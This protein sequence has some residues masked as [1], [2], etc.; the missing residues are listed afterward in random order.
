MLAS[1][2]RIIIWSGLN[3]S[4]LSNDW[5]TIETGVRT[6]L[7]SKDLL[8]VILEVFD[9]R[10]GK[11][12]GRWDFDISYSVSTDDDGGFWV[13]T[14]A[15]QCAIKKQGLI[16][17]DCQYSILVTTKI[18]SPNVPGWAPAELRSTDRFVRH[19]IGTTIGA[20]QL[21][22]GAAFWRLKP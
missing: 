13:D 21:A 20:S 10:T 5:V 6:W 14:D 19:C 1:L 12:A 22:S 16:P 4:K 2:K 15:I 17:T 18:G 7:H 8:R 3:P 11:L 9:P